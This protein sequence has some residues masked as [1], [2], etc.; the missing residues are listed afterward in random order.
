MASTESSR[1]RVCKAADA[2][3]EEA[4]KAAHDTDP[5]GRTCTAVE[6]ADRAFACG[7]WERDIEDAEFEMAHTEVCYIIE[8]EIRIACGDGTVVTAV[9]GDILTVPQGAKGRWTNVAP[10]RKFWATYHE[11]EA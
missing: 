3:W 8:G 4:A 6:S 11:I 9:P 7:F 2:A 10:V 5:P 1:I